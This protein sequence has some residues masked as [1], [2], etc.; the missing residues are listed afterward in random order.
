MKCSHLRLGKICK[1]V[2]LAST[3]SSEDEQLKMTGLYVMTNLKAPKQKRY[4]SIYHN[5]KRNT[6]LVLSN[7][8][9]WLVGTLQNFEFVVIKLKIESE[10]FQHFRRNIDFHIR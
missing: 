8:G 9:V 3:N 2:E 10:F 1:T 5:I 6:Y 7:E 4:Q